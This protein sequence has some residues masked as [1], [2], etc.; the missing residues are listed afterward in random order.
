MSRQWIGDIQDDRLGTSTCGGVGDCNFITGKCT[1][2]GGNWGVF[3]GDGCETLSCAS[4]LDTEDNI[5]KKCS[6]NGVCMT[7]RQLAPYAYDEKKEMRRFT[8]TSSW[9]ADMIR[10]C[11]CF[12]AMSIDNFF[13][14]DYLVPKDGTSYE[15]GVV[16]SVTAS[17]GASDVSLSYNTTKFYRG[18]FS[19]AAS[20][21]TGYYCGDALCPYGDN[22]TT[23]VGVNEVQTFTCRASSGKFQL[24]FRENVTMFISFDDTT[25]ELEKAL[26]Q[27]Y[28]L[29]DVTVTLVD[30][31]SG[32]DASYSIC[33]IAD[34]R[35]ST[36]EFNT[37][38]GDLPLM[39]VVSS[40]LAHSTPSSLLKTVTETIKG[41]K[42]DLE[43]SG[44]GICH[45]TGVCECMHGFMSSNGTRVS[46]GQRGDC[47]Y[48]NPLAATYGDMNHH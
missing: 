26:E 38:P 34:S 32:S 25:Q 24:F 2:C 45:W 29:N 23:S 39:Q 18:P 28:V 17:S 37:Q 30:R 9:D 1:S 31:V 35:Y 16:A 27:M 48:Y 42:E 46:P 8:Y 5:F 3:D 6:S 14:D 10:G 12:R 22:P 21:W 33:S 20:D 4:G 7:L 40:T 47:S 11:A 36:V 15:T 43:C 41:T 44:Q 13:Y 19:Q